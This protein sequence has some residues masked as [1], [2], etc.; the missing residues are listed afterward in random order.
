[1]AKSLTAKNIKQDLDSRFFENTNPNRKKRMNNIC[2]DT[3]SMQYQGTIGEFID[4]HC[5]K[6]AGTWNDYK[7]FRNGSRYRC[8]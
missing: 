5:N 3:H 2:K 8:L 6:S 4:A 1:M 7:A